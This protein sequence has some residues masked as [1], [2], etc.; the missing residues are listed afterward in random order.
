[1]LLY[2]TEIRRSQK[3]RKDKGSPI[4]CKGRSRVERYLSPHFCK[5]TAL[6]SS[7]QRRVATN[8][9]SPDGERLGWPV[10]APGIESGLPDCKSGVLN[11]TICTTLTI[12]AYIGWWTLH[13]AEMLYRVA[14]ILR[15]RVF[16]CLIRNSCSFTVCVMLLAMFGTLAALFLNCCVLC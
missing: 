14:L 6:P 4:F 15:L 5:P 8:L 10:D 7:P 16:V 2:L 12:L 9:S 3:E 13:L 1:M 11:T